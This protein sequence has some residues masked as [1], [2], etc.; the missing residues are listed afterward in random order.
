TGY[1]AEMLGLDVNIE[2]DLGIDSIKRVEILS[3]FQKSCPPEQ[4]EK[5]QAA[6]D[7]LSSRRTLR[8]IVDVL[9][10]SLNGSQS[11][12]RAPKRAEQA[13]ADASGAPPNG[14][15]AAVPRFVMRAVEAP[16]AA[17]PRRKYRD[18]LWVITDEESGIAAALAAGLQDRGETAVLLRHSERPAAPEER[19]YFA[20]LR[21]P[22]EVETAL[23]SIRARHGRIG[24]V[25]HLLPL[26]KGPGF[27]QM[28]LPDWRDRVRL[29]I[30]S[31][32]AL[33]RFGEDDLVARG[34]SGGAR[35][36]VVTAM[37]GKFATEPKPEIR[38][39][40]AGVASFLKT[41]SLELPEVVCKAIDVEGRQPAPAL[42]EKLLAEL[43]SEDETLEVG[44]AGDR[45]I[46]LAPAVAQLGADS[47]G[48]V[49]DRE[50]VVLVTGGARGITAEIAG[51][52]AAHYRPRLILAGLSPLPPAEE[53]PETAGLTDAKEIKAVLWKG[54]SPADRRPASVEAKYNRLLR[55]REIRSNLERLRSA[56][57]TVEYH[58]LDVRDEQ[59]V[60]ALLEHVY[61]SYGRI[62]MVI[63]G[64]GIIEDK[65][66]RDKTPESFDRVL[67]TK[68][69]SAFTLVRKLRPEGL[70]TLVFM[71]SV[72]AT[73]GNRGQCDY[74]A[75]NG[76]LNGLSAL[77]SAH[78]PG[79]VVALNW[80][81][82]D[83]M[84]MASAGV[85]AQ[86]LERGIH[87]IAPESG[88]AAAALEIQAG[89]KSEPVVALGDGPW[90]K[91][92]EQVRPR[93]ARAAAAGTA[94]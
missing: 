47:A 93:P 36:C 85:R 79:R 82:W 41:L 52:L 1:P 32:Y 43:T 58:Q 5:I 76:V 53:P 73:F 66:L 11:P 13:A 89:G 40:H 71:S 81:P 42:A 26:R 6:M 91:Q 44:L 25:V 84:G 74:A 77:L 23:E 48:V 75:A 34:K 90:A 30:K 80:G 4:Q 21:R 27:W 3:V 59:A 29:E 70:K 37:G 88:V 72:T 54:L 69:D 50:S 28:S 15:P 63:H 7:R 57:A 31:L 65:L 16:P 87:L 33:A 49:A 62:D 83:K 10:A 55:D 67:H 68:V 35:F 24:A 61:R 60:E 38:P 20:D 8:E 45:R 14:K 64:A 9:A 78:W 22:E 17:R 92:A 56:G 12:A 39:I 51:F 86:F 18:R 19:V 94:A 2:A 46:T